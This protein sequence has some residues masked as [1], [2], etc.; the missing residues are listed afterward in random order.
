MWIGS[1]FTLE[2]ERLR[3]EKPMKAPCGMPL[4]LKGSINLSHTVWEKG[5]IMSKKMRIAI[6]WYKP[7]QW[8]LLKACSVDKEVIEDTFEEWV[9]NAEVQFEGLKK[10]GLNIHKVVI[11]MD[12]LVAWCRDNDLPVDAESRAKYASELLR[13]IYR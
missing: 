10:E 8:A 12:A 9:T 6:A 4:N 3:S 1:G 2:R 7:E 5:N 11:D 13:E